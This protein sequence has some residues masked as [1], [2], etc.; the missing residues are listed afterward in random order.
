M[1]EKKSAPAAMARRATVP[2]SSCAGRAW[3]AIAAS[4]A[5]PAP[6]A[7]APCRANPIGANV[8]WKAAP[9]AMAMAATST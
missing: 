5:G 8:A 9:T 2:S 3:A 1:A 4:V 6:E 7:T